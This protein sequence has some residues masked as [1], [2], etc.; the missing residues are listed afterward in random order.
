MPYVIGHRGAAAVAP[1]NTMASFALALQAGADGLELDFQLTKDGQ[2]VVI[3]DQ[4]LKRTT[5]ADGMVKDRTLAELKQLDAGSWFAPRF[6]G[7]RI[8]T[9][10]EVL[11]L[12]RGRAFVNAEIKNLPYRYPGIEERLLVAVRRTGFPLD[13]LIVSSFDH[14]SL[15]RVQA[16]EPRVAIAALFGHY[17]V[18][19]GDLPG[20]VLHP[21]WGVAD[22]AFMAKARAAGRTVNVWTANDPDAWEHLVRVGVDGIITDDPARLRAWLTA[23]SA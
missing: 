8:P 1:E 5:G 7:E 6:A 19:L 3:H 11:D 14:E 23:R 10:E 18:A 17:P 12:A 13:Q 20:T 4:T 16:L 15:L 21:H 22:G 2:L 9:L